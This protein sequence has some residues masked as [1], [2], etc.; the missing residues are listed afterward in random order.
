MLTRESVLCTL[1]RKCLLCTHPV[2]FSELRLTGR[3]NATKK[4]KKTT[5]WMAGQILWFLS[6][7]FLKFT[8]ASFLRPSGIASS[9]NVRVLT[10]PTNPWVDWEREWLLNFHDSVLVSVFLRHSELVVVFLAN[11]IVS[12]ACAWS[13]SV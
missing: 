7:I 2:A 6:R 12:Q 5:I 1:S 10:Y 9:I 13:R 11:A 4:K 3:E 8:A